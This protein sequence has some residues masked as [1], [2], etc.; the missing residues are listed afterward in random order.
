MKPPKLALGDTVAIISPSNDISD[1]EDLLKKACSNFEKST[2]LK[3]ILAPNVLAKHYYSAGTAQQRIDD[4]HWALKNPDVKGIVFSCGGDTAIDLVDK[5]DYDLIKQN[6]KI[7][8][9]ISDATTLLN[10]INAKTGLITFLGLEFL[11]FADQPM[12]YEVAAIKKAWFGEEIGA[13]E[14]NPNWQDFDNLP[15]SYKG[16]QTIREG[17]AEGRIVGGNGTC[18]AQLY[19]TQYCP[20]MT[21]CILVLEYYMLHKKS[22]HRML[23]QLRLWGAL[24][25]SKGLIIGYCLGSDEPDK[26]GNERSLKDLVLEVTDGYDFPIMWVG[27]IGHNIDNIIVPIGATLSMDATN[28]SLYIADKVVT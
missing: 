2:G 12:T 23:A 4:F 27:E 13:I 17:Q 24:D 26:T 16:W 8:S 6:P 1:R 9:G 22:I 19:N 10:P 14:P 18:F 20:D 28:K 3:T 15:T 5:L 25:K 11:D 7:I 21:G